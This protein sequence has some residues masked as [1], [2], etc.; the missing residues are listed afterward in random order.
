MR[1]IPFEILSPPPVAVFS[2]FLKLLL[3]LPLLLAAASPYHTL[4]EIVVRSTSLIAAR[5]RRPTGEHGDLSRCR[6][7]NTRLADREIDAPRTLLRVL[8]PGNGADSQILAKKRSFLPSSQL[9]ACLSA[10][11]HRSRTLGGPESRDSA[12]C[13]DH[14]Q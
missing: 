1:I 13:V 11:S 3:L 14:S 2:A 6:C 4:G 8:S 10:L 12:S 7:T 5:R 9:Q